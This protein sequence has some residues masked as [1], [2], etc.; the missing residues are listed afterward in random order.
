M[1]GWVT[2]AALG[3][4]IAAWWQYSSFCPHPYSGKEPQVVLITGVSSGIGIDLATQYGL[5]GA[6]LILAARRK[7]LLEGTAA[8]ALRAGAASALAVVTDMTQRDQVGALVDTVKQKFGRLDVLLLNHATVDDAMVLEYE[9][10]TSLAAAV[11]PVFSANVLGSIYATHAALP[12]LEKSK[13]HIAVV[14]SASTIAAAPFHSA[15]VASKR[16]LNG[17]FDTLR[18]E[19]HV[20][21]SSITVGVLVLGMIKTE[22]VVRDAPDAVIAIEPSEC[23]RGMVCAIRG[24]WEEAFVPHWYHPMAVALQLMG[25][26]AREMAINHSYLFNVKRYLERI[27]VAA[28]NIAAAAN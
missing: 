9:N 26:K 27:A 23:A 18:H 20:L 11:E 19:L 28:R 25:S 17:F 5:E 1:R 16:A 4:G 21:N 14:S 24:R 10:S 2:L 7:A 12:L 13:G 3:A 15:Y 8:K 22:A 6:H